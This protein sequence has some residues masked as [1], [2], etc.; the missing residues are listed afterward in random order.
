MKMVK[1]ILIIGM[2][3]ALSNQVNIKLDNRLDGIV[4]QPFRV[5]F[6]QASKEHLIYKIDTSAFN[7]LSIDERYLK[8]NCPLHKLSINIFENLVYRLDKKW[9]TNTS[10][11]IPNATIIELKHDKIIKLENNIK[12]F[13]QKICS[14]LQQITTDLQELNRIFNKLSENHAFTAID[15]I[16]NDKLKYDIQRISKRYENKLI[17]PFVFSKWFLASFKN[18]MI[19]KYHFKENFIYL[20]YE[21]PLFTNKIIDLFILHPKPM[22]WEDNIYLYNTSIQYAII[23]T[24]KKLFYTEKE[25]KRDCKSSMENIFCETNS[26]NGDHCDKYY[27]NK[28]TYKFHENCFIK[29]P[30]ENMITQ[31]G[32]K[33]YFTVIDKMDILINQFGIVYTITIGEC[34]KIIETIDYSL[35]NSYFSFTPYGDDKYEIFFSNESIKQPIFYRFNFET[36]YYN[37]IIISTIHFIILTIIFK[38]IEYL[39]KI[40]QN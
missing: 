8:Q 7:F 39:C 34:S 11:K 17:T 4:F 9:T 30:Y 35:N 3:V 36:K 19:P 10:E 31:I 24:N 18:Y 26:N 20:Q 5:V 16:S 37:I 15:F 33:L 23:E 13:D 14:M 28:N 2:M 29:L 38:L 6:A 21:I 12:L 32:K 1:H 25:F 27:I 22:I 40:K